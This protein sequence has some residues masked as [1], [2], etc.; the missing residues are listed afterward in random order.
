MRNKYI[1]FFS[2]VAL[3]ATGCKRD[4]LDI[5]T[6]PNSATSAGPELVL[7]A[8]LVTTGA[9]MNPMVFPHTA[10]NGWMGY[11][12][13]S[14][15][16]AIS[17]SDF[18]T[19]KQTNDFGDGFF[20]NVYDNLNDYNYVEV[21][22]SQQNKPFYTG[23]AKVMKAYNF[24]M[25]VDLFNN[26]PY[27]E[28]FKGTSVI[29]PKYDE[30]RVIYEDLIK[31]L[32]TAI[33]SLTRA[34]AEATATSDI[35]FKGNKVMWRMFANTLKLRML[36]RQ[37]QVSGRAAYIQAEIAKILAE[38]SGFL[39]VGQD[40]GVNPGYLN[41]TGKSNPFWA[42][43]Y[44]VAGT[45]IND[46]WRANQFGIDFYRA[47][48]DPRLTR[49][50]GPTSSDATKYQGNV[51]GQISGLVGSNSS[52]FGPGVLKAFNQDAILMTAAESYF[53]QAEAALRGWLTADAKM[54]YEQ[55]VKESFRLL[56]VPN[57]NTAATTY[58]TQ[59]D[60]KNV[61]WDAATTLNERIALVI[62]Q[63][64]AAMNSITPI[65]AYADYRRLGLP[66][67]IPLSLSPYI[68]VKKIPIRFLYPTSEF[69]TNANN[70]NSQGK[71]DQHTS[72]IFWI[73]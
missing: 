69:R 53:L 25:L 66:A 23:A 35:L 63:K 6:N 49:V 14:G 55:G 42:S 47:N 65:E 1:V 34:N 71:I 18:T 72:K 27:S 70:V 20:Q 59:A 68:D 52:V 58:Y 13:I 46:F 19:Y 60:N 15:S 37:T 33:T 3:I 54:L 10:F 4:F 24:H 50:Y 17:T 2:L 43:N 62:R 36:M 31:Q 51:L 73:P 48:N 26:V 30:G 32:D 41:S 39:S 7:P 29:N 45:Y 22:A 64:W 57:A 8:A 21:Q 44:N 61:N 5:N 38:R 11:W 28:A 40:A 56:G 9:R 16:Y 67:D 12:A